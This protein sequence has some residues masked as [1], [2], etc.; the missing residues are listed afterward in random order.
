MLS[1]HLQASPASANRWGSA[2]LATAAAG[3]Q[4]K[5][6][7]LLYNLEPKGLGGD[8]F[9]I[10]WLFLQHHR[11]RKTVLYWVEAGSCSKA[12]FLSSLFSAQLRRTWGSD[13]FATSYWVFLFGHCGA[14][15]YDVGWINLL[16]LFIEVLSWPVQF[17][18]IIQQRGAIQLL[19]NFCLR[20]PGG[21]MGK[22]RAQDLA[23]Q[24]VLAWF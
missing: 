16:I 23:G 19:Q 8:M 24:P 2:A 5:Q 20:V 4:T 11:C 18:W 14:V 10:L 12:W 15:W 6:F 17:H 3:V 9:L 7:F 21:C 22:R 1:Y 13:Y